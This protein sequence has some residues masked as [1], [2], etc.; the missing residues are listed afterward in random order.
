MDK[1]LLLLCSYDQRFFIQIC[2]GLDGLRS[3]LVQLVLGCLFF[4]WV[5]TALESATGSV[6][7][8]SVF[9]LDLY[10]IQ[11]GEYGTELP[12]ILRRYEW[13]QTRLNS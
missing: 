7:L 1:N 8:R 13:K 9:F 6:D 4:G 3:R 10:R 11:Y 2:R 12:S 5:Y